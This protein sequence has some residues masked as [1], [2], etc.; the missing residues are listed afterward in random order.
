MSKKFI[1]EDPNPDTSDWK[2]EWKGMPEFVQDDLRPFRAIN[3]RFRNEA[4][5]EDF[6]KLIGQTITPNQKAL[7]FPHMENRKTSHLIYVD[8]NES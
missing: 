4:D 7:W 5:V 6:M 3:V 1:V 8:D 2:N